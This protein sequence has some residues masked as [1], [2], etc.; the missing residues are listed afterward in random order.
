MTMLEVIRNEFIS[1]VVNPQ[2]GATIQHIG[3]SLNP[4]T[5]VLAWYEWDEPVALPLDFKEDESWKH[6]LS[7]YRGGWQFLTPNA[8]KECVFNGVRHSFHGESSYMPWSVAKKEDDSITLEIILR[9]QLRVTRVLTIDSFMASIT[10]RTTISNPTNTPQEVVIVEHAAF[11]GSPNMVVSAPDHSKWRF[12]GNF[13]E[14]DRDSKVWSEPGVISNK[15]AHP[16]IDR[17]ERM[18]YLVSGSEGWISIVDTVKGFGAKLLWNPIEL[19]YIWY[20]Q[21]Q[22]SPGFPFYGRAEI[23][24]LEPASCL[25]G[26]GLTGAS[27]SGRSRVIFAGNEYSFSISL[28]LI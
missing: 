24:A 22:K 6:W 14:D 9:S 7:R 21:E 17:T 20:W 23:T 8:G 10:C 13:K 19:P 15:L 2:N 25:P 4:A 16:I 3:K 12:D 28:K 5:N 26:D 11:Q 1:I 18:T 27:E